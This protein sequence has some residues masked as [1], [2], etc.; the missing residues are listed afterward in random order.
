M[1]LP[2]PPSI[3]KPRIGLRKP[4]K[5]GSTAQT[6]LE[7]FTGSG[8]EDPKWADRSCAGFDDRL[9]IGCKTVITAC[10]E[11]PLVVD[12]AFTAVIVIAPPCPPLQRLPGFRIDLTRPLNGDSEGCPC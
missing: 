5:A 7:P 2:H 10:A 1:S 9:Y 12:E 4:R 8:R 6:Q 11:L 3:A